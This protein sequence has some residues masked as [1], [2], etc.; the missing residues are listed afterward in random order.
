MGVLC[1]A[2]DGTKVRADAAKMRA[3]MARHKP[4]SGPLDI[5]LGPGGLVDLEFAVH[6]LQLATGLGFDPRLE[7]AIA[8][9]VDA[10]HLTKEVDADLRLLSR[11]LVT[12]RL[13]APDGSVPPAESRP[14]VAEVCGHP[15]WDALLAAHDEARQRV[16]AL[17]TRI[18]EGE[19]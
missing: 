13:V 14:L 6:T 10:G 2:H 9:L 1:A 8:A 11:I 4:P 3:D 15:D 19:A 5:K 12:M 17:W 16:A 7:Y 18:K